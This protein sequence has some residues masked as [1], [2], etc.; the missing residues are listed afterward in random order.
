MNMRKCSLCHLKGQ[1]TISPSQCANIPKF[2]ISKQLLQF[3]TISILS[4]KLYYS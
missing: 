2:G 4:F 3:Q 1:N